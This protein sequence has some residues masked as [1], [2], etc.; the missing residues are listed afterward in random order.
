MQGAKGLK[1]NQ[2]IFPKDMEKVQR[3]NERLERQL[4]ELRHKYVIAAANL[5]YWKG[6]ALLLEAKMVLTTPTD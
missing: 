5:R 2:L 6:K 3:V 1:V 4:A